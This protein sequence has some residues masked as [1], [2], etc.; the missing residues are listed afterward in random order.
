MAQTTKRRAPRIDIAPGTIPAVMVGI[1]AAIQI[2]VGAKTL[3]PGDNIV[4]DHCECDGQL[5]VLVT[6]V[7]PF[8]PPVC[9]QGWRLGVTF[10]VVRCVSTIDNNGNPPSSA[11]MLEDEMQILS[12]MQV[13]AR[14]ILSLETTVPAVLGVKLGEWWP[15]GP[16]SGCAGGRWTSTITL[17]V[18]WP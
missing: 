17:P 13:L 10:S 12:D 4:W 14:E 6:S 3:Y 18:C 9:P 5:G 15:E 2:D 8:G 16:Q 11:E 1:L 7:A